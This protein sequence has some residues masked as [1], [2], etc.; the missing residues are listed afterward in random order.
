MMFCKTYLLLG[1]QNMSRNAHV[2]FP[3]ILK[4]LDE[5]LHT[6][7]C[8][9]HTAYSLLCTGYYVLI[10]AYYVLPPKVKTYP[11]GGVWMDLRVPPPGYAFIPR[12]NTV[13]AV[14]RVGCRWDRR[15]TGT[16][17]S[18]SGSDVRARLGWRREETEE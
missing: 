2:Q 12:Q 1:T 4:C 16:L 7:C 18:G 13:T 14:R 8:V 17:A 10:A 11:Q 9:L 15:P 6:A 3:P 5:T